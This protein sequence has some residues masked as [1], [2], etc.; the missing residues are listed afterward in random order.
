MVRAVSGD[1]I[2]VTASAIAREGSSGVEKT[3]RIRTE[4]PSSQTQSVKVPPLSMAILRGRRAG[5]EV[6]DSNT[7][8][9]QLA[10]G[11]WHS[12]TLTTDHCDRTDF[13]INLQLLAHE[14]SVNRVQ[15]VIR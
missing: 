12:Q 10:V 13:R 14:Q 9:W 6:S 2:L 15:I 3:F 8:D 1:T 5:M 4:D 7:S 11:N